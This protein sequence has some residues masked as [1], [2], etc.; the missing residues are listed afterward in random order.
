MVEHSYSL[1]HWQTLWQGLAEGLHRRGPMDNRIHPDVR[2]FHLLRDANNGS[3]DLSFTDSFN[4]GLLGVVFRTT[5]VTHKH[6]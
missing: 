2:P 4:S 6:S 3:R 1:V 5:S